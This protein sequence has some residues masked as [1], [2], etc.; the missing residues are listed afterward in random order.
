MESPYKLAKNVLLSG[1]SGAAPETAGRFASIDLYGAPACENDAA[2]GSS[3]FHLENES[4]TGDIS[5]Y[6][7]FPGIELIYNDM[8]MSVLQPASAAGSERYGDK[9]LQR[10]PQ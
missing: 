9:L 2:D 7:V 4:G 5:L 1:E 6:R 10:G 3:S 8:H